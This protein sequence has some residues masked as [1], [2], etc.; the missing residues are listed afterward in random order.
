MEGGIKQN[1]PLDSPIDVKS[2]DMLVPI[3]Q[4]KFL[5]NRQRFQGHTLPTSL[6]YEH[7]GYAC[8]WDVWNFDVYE[9]EYWP[10]VSDE[11]EGPYHT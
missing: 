4:A 1:I 11:E 5:H 2:S 10:L 3:N 7:D 8:G 9:H 6:R